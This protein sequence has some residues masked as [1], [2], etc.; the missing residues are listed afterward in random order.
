[1]NRSLAWKT[2]FRASFLQTLGSRGLWAMVATCILSSFASVFHNHQGH[3]DALEHYRVEL[4]ERQRLQFQQ[5]L[6]PSDDRTDRSLRVIRPPSASGV[7]VLGVE[8]TMPAGWDFGPAGVETLAPYA[9]QE[10]L[11]AFDILTDAESVMRL[12]G[13]MLAIV[14]GFWSVT[15]D[16]RRGWLSAA[17]WL[18][19][20]TWWLMTAL[21]AAGSVALGLIALIWV[22]GSVMFARWLSDP[23]AQTTLVFVETWFLAWIYLVTMF[24]T[25]AA[26]ARLVT[27]ALVGMATVLATWTVLIFLGPQLA[28]TA[29]RMVSA[30]PPRVRMEQERRENY[31]DRRKDAEDALTASLAAF[32][33]TG[34]ERS[35]VAPTL[36]GAFP[37]FEAAWRD[38]MQRAR[39]ESTAARLLWLDLQAQ[40][41]GRLQAVAR[42]TPGTLLQS[43]LSTANGQGWATLQS[44]EEA[45]TKHESAINMSL[46]DNRSRITL[47]IPWTGELILWS[48]IWHPSLPYSEL[49][50]FDVAATASASD[51]TALPLDLAAGLLQ[52]VTVILAA[53]WAPVISTSR[54]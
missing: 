27:N 17:P 36:T 32:M 46:F 45:V 2:V 25:G 14:L 5:P 44:W 30:T 23:G 13:G 54:K 10:P 24:G 19:V 6:G 3:L 4:Q 48:Q 20:P 9:G 29:V 43:A 35:D 21:L 42:L 12:F 39:V 41:I 50:Q 7:F 37:R 38:E 34:T 1:M 33:P 15:R 18:P 8:R 40:R 47:R 53:A 16:R 22:A 51:R 28:A 52:V 31:A 26:I 49:P 11:A